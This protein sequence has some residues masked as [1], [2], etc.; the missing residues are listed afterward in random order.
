MITIRKGQ[1]RGQ[2]RFSWLQSHHSFSFGHYYDPAHMGFGPLRVINQDLV[3]PGAG[4]ETH[5]HRNMEIVSYVLAGALEHKDSMGNGSVIRPGD[6]QRMT[7]GTGIRHSEFN[8]SKDAPV[9]FLQIWI[10]PDR[11]DLA[12]GYEEKHFDPAGRQGEL[13]LVGSADGR[14][15]SLTIHQDVDLYA[16]L[17]NDTEVAS[18][19]QRP[20]R[21][22]W[23]HVARGAL[24][25]NGHVLEEGDGLASD[26]PGTLHLGQASNADILVFDM[27]A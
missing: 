7:A 1:D 5:G 11:K 14:D 19:E 27:A 13:A 10:E 4:F 23:I 8:H 20:G 16:G 3:A 26:E 9:E 15:G 17:L 22:I 12:P 2:A 24:W 21:K 6:V 18:I 25:I